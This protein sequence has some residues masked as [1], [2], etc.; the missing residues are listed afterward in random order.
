VVDNRQPRMDEP[1]VEF[2]PVHT[3]PVALN[4]LLDQ[5]L[6]LYIADASLDIQPMVHIAA[7][8]HLRKL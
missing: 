5:I 1:A 2:Q 6:K 4:T 3:P 7:Q 8:F